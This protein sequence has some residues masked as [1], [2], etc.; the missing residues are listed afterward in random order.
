MLTPHW[1]ALL[2][3]AAY[4]SRAGDQT[5]SHSHTRQALSTGELVSSAP[6]WMSLGF[7]KGLMM[8]SCFLASTS[9]RE[10]PPWSMCSRPLP[11]SWSGLLYS[12]HRV[13]GVLYVISLSVL[14][15]THFSSLWSMLAFPFKGQLV[16]IFDWVWSLCSSVDGAL[17]VISKKSLPSPTWQ[18]SFSFFF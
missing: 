18:K 14:Q 10:L 17:D 16:F 15:W 1:G 3:F 7:P 11:L 6:L 9:V 4:F 13:W 12:H 2:C 5:W 8:L